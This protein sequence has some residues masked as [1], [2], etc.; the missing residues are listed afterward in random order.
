[1]WPIGMQLCGRH[2]APP[3]AVGG[4]EDVVHASR[5]RAQLAGLSVVLGSSVDAAAWPSFRPFS[6]SVF[7]VPSPRAILGS[8]ELPKTSRHDD[9]QR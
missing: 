2:L 5:R 1:M 3:E 8:L 7:A 4:A 6:N 9:E